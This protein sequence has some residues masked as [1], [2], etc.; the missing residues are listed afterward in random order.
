VAENTAI[1]WCD[2]TG[3]PFLVCSEVS[4]GC[5][6]CYAREL[7]LRRLAPIVRKAYKA[8]GFK[9][10][11]TRPVWGDTAP[12]VLTKGFWVEMARLNRRA[13]KEGRRY[14]VFPSMIDWLDD[15]P[16]GIIDQEGHWLERDAVIADFLK[17]I[18]DTPNL[19]W[20][21]LTKRPENWRERIEAAHDWMA[22]QAWDTYVYCDTQAQ[23]LYPWISAHER[24]GFHNDYAPPN[25]WIGT[26]VEDQERAN[27]RIP[28]LL[29]IP[30]RVR[31]LSCEPLLGPVEFS[32]VTHRADCVSRLGKPAL[33]GI[34]WV[35][36]GGESGPK[37]R[38][39]HP[40]WAR[41]LRDQCLAARVPFFFKQ[42][43]EWLAVSQSDDD[44][45]DTSPGSRKESKFVC[46]HEDTGTGECVFR[47][48]KKAAGRLLD[49][50]EW[51]EFPAVGEAVAA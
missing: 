26:T 37:A 44:D 30:A 2:H 31:F 51:N 9:D 50:R 7:M 20:L 15:M 3:G 21:L 45:P 40:D 33:E 29:S 38:P 41:S 36:C 25:V 8:A 10:W 18:H 46:A 1:E 49:G 48:G 47:V 27:E 12:R 6:H 24:T 14:K 19:E 5:A 11:E 23:F 22:S 28:E 35:I 43:G 16:A 42:W 17:L 4:P 34:H 32:D 13:A 39:M